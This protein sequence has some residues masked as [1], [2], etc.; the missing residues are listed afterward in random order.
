GR[1]DHHSEYGTFLSPRLSVLLRSAAGISVRASGGNGF[2]APVPWT[3]ETEA[4]GLGRLLAAELEA[5]RAS[6]A[7]LD[8]SY[9]TEPIELNAT[10]FGSRIRDAV[11]VRPAPADPSRLEMF[12]AR[13]DVRT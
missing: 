10:W 3:E 13:G 5:E 8:V 6:T 11:Q 4:T 1:L 7:S 2:Y 9:A 12:N